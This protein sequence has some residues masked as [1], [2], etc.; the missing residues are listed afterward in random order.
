LTITV[1]RL[2]A[3]LL[4]LLA[5]CTFELSPSGPP[6]KPVPSEDVDEPP[7]NVGDDGAPGGDAA[8]SIDWTEVAD[9]PLARFEGQSA[10]VGGKL[11]VFGGYTDG[12]VMPKSFE[13][14]VYDPASDTWERLP[15]M[16][17][18]IT[19]AGTTAHG[20]N[21]YLAGGVVG[22]EDPDQLEKIDATTEVWRF[23][24]ENLDWSEMTPLPEP[25]GAGALVVLGDTL[26][27]F[28]GTGEDRYQEVWDHWQLDLDDPGEWVSRAPI[29]NPRNHLAGVVAGGVIYAIGGQHGHNETLETQ[30][31]VQAYDPDFDGWYD[32]AP[33]PTGLGHI[34]NS[35]FALEDKIVIVGGETSGY[36]VFT[37]EVLV[38]DPAS[39]AWS[40]ATPLPTA[41]N[42]L[43][44][45]VIGGDI[46]IA[47]GSERS[48]RT[49]KGVLT[50][51]P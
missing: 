22:S 39:D 27:F 32:V 16:L 34:S 18:P 5:A 36:G 14:D 7:E 3:S 24:T 8:F 45:G 48:A 42:S 31:S 47:G 9:A 46:F 28:G 2:S 51:N 19:H 17:R 50:E 43:V 20:T 23:D 35:T 1:R 41:E 21:I 10:V 12:S 44:G 33:L 40:N 6:D 11:Y 29:P 25:R 37:D 4:V 26:H 38:Y 30:D 15:D 49:L 13:V